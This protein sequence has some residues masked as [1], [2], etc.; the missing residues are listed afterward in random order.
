[1]L[2]DDPAKVHVSFETASGAVL[3]AGRCSR[4]G[5]LRAAAALL[6]TRIARHY[7]HATQV[8]AD[9]DQQLWEIAGLCAQEIVII[10]VA[11]PTPRLFSQ[12]GPLTS[13]A[14]EARRLFRARRTMWRV[15]ASATAS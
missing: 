3:G 9:A 15:G 2:T 10:A 12:N 13:S 11:A 7:L 14:P 1:M 8:V 4:Y 5:T 6:P